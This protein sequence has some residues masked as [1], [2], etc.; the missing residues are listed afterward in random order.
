MNHVVE[1]TR[2]LRHEADARQVKDAEIGAVTGWGGHGH[3][4][5][6]VLRR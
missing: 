5:L 1:A 4:A 6:A 3:G 2:Q